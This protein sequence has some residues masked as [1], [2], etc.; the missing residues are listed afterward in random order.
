[1]FD[2]AYGNE[3]EA[4]HTSQENFVNCQIPDVITFSAFRKKSTFN[5]AVK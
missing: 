1:M 4:H 5:A 2:H 3:Y